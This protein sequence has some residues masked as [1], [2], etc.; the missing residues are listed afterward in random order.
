MGMPTP[1][2]T[3]RP[4]FEVVEEAEVVAGAAEAAPELVD[5]ALVVADVDRVVDA[6]VIV[7][8]MDDEEVEELVVAPGPSFAR[9]AVGTAVWYDSNW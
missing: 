5:W 3:P 7:E 1:R 2:P 6:V 4:I 9:I 8:A